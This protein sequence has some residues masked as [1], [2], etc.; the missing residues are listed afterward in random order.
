MSLP[1]LRESNGFLADAIIDASNFGRYLRT[2]ELEHLKT[3]E[4]QFVKAVL[5]KSLPFRV[6]KIKDSKG[7]DKYEPQFKFQTKQTLWLALIHQTSEISMWLKQLM[8]ICKFTELWGEE[9]HKKS[10]V[11][12]DGQ[13]TEFLIYSETETIFRML[14][15]LEGGLC[16]SEHEARRGSNPK[17]LL[18][19][20][21]LMGVFKTKRKD[22]DSMRNEMVHNINFAQAHVVGGRM[23]DWFVVQQQPF[24]PAANMTKT[25][26]RRGRSV[27]GMLRAEA[28]NVAQ[29][30]SAL[31]KEWQIIL[32]GI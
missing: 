27:R 3:Y 17:T 8:T 32:G 5:G 15:R 1:T 22:F 19:I 31:Y 2:R 26:E 11:E 25:F 12:S 13:W 14:E 7:N 23:W 10:G 30:I 16:K 21:K 18:E 9:W 24:Q 28:V 29:T 4:P 6:N 20:Q